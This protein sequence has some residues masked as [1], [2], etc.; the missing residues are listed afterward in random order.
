MNSDNDMIYDL[1]GRAYD[2]EH[3]D[4][5]IALTEEAVRLADIHGDL[6]LQIEAKMAL[7]EAATFGGA[8]EKALVAFSW[9][10]GQ[11]DKNPDLISEY[12]LL[13][14]YKWI[15]GH[16]DAFPQISKIQIDGLLSDMT[17]RYQRAGVSLRP[18]HQ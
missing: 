8:P 11:Y 16:A 1:L 12:D 4:Q 9:C 15:V 17:A 3:G 18:I 13:W 6:D 14:K 5:Q 7:V 10:L 2:F